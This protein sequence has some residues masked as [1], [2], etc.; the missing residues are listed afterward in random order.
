MG[1]SV[2]KVFFNLAFISAVIYLGVGFGYRAFGSWLWQMEMPQAQ[3]QAM[4]GSRQRG[5]P[6]PGDFKGIVERNLFGAVAQKASPEPEEVKMEKIETLKP[7]S[8]KVLLIGTVTGSDGGSCAVIEES[9]KKKQRL[10]RTGESIQGA[11]IK[12]ILRGKV[13]LRVGGRD[14]VLSIA[15]SSSG[16]AKL[17]PGASSQAHSA[18]EPASRSEVTVKKEDLESSFANLNELLTQMR[19]KPYFSDGKPSGLAVAWVKPDSFFTAMGLRS[20]D[21]IQAI[22]ESPIKSADDIMA[23]YKEMKIGSDISLQVLRE[24]KVH[25][26]DYKFEAGSGR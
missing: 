17:R 10:Y 4:K 1:G 21:V 5:F 20:G 8:L 18:S 19:I 24:H 23:V 6:S 16:K 3:G 9:D 22:N 13:L 12:A 26:I 15:D 2:L 25:T 14:E 7:T 11:T